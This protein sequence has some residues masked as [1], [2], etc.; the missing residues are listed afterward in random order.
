MLDAAKSPTWPIK[1]SIIVTIIT[2]KYEYSKLYI[3]FRPTTS[4]NEIRKKEEETEERTSKMKNIKRV[5]DKSNG[6]DK[7]YKYRTAIYQKTDGTAITN[8][9]AREIANGYIVPAC[10]ALIDDTL[11]INYKQ[12]R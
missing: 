11:Y 4:Y 9:E 6:Y 10:Y 12:N 3:L 5:S 2:Y 1:L 7:Q 8:D